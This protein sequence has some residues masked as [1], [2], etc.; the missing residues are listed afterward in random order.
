MI[1]NIQSMVFIL[2]VCDDFVCAVVLGV[3]N[4]CPLGGAVTA[5]GAGGDRGSGARAG[6][7]RGDGSGG[8]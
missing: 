2:L 4:L 5:T 8:D 1:L 6:H 3:T 7:L